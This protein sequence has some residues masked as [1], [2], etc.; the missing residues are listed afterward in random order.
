MSYEFVTSLSLFAFVS[1]ITPGPNNL[2]LMA[3]GANYGFKRTIPHLLGVSMGFVFMAVLLGMGLVNLFEAYPVTYQVLKVTAV[4]YLFYLAWK[5]AN[6]STAQ[7]SQPTGKPFTFFQAVLFQ[8][9][10]P[11]VWAMALTTL[12]V[13]THDRS[14][15]SVLLVS[16]IFG[17][18]NL[19]CVAVWATIG[20]Q[21][22]R[23]LT[24]PKQ[25]RLF[26]RIMAI[27]LIISLYP[28]LIN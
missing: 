7:A 10:N 8:W 4:V 24:K 17:A 19:P 20:Q 22:A 28:V 16:V 25:L 3:S 15:Q 9:V 6:A 27:L 26:N 11:K 12:S 13:Y 23:L 5:I 14:M 21:M 18:V 1:S 2:M